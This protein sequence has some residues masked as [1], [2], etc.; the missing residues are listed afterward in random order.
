MRRVDFPSEDFT[1]RPI[2]VSAFYFKDRAE[3]IMACVVV[4]GTAF[5][6]SL[7]YFDPT[8]SQSESFFD[9]NDKADSRKT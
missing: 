3:L 8:S 4:F 9:S 6:K 2:G 1:R 7:F 5:A